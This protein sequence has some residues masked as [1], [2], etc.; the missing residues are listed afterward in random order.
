MPS[1]RDLL[2]S[3]M[4]RL[5]QVE[6]QLKNAQTQLLEKV[7]PLIC[8]N[9]LFLFPSNNSKSRWFHISLRIH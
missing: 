7:I 4:S 9:N 5:A 2:G 6:Q 8:L 3:M 1:D